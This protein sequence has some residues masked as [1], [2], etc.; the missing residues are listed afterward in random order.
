MSTYSIY[1][2]LA[3]MGVLEEP[4]GLKTPRPTILLSTSTYVSISHTT[5]INVFPS[6]NYE[7]N[8]FPPTSCHMSPP[9]GVRESDYNKIISYYSHFFF[10]NGFHNSYGKS[11]KSCFPDYILYVYYGYMDTY[12]AV[13]VAL[14]IR[15][16]KSTH[17]LY[18]SWLIKEKKQDTPNP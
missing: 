4:S 15:W 6:R 3:V 12:V 11:L 2:Y 5:C 8:N 1:F 14:Y 16:A 17:T 13:I 7:H 10:Y 18:N 9:S